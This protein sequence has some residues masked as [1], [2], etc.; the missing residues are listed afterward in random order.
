MRV[1]ISAP[2]LAS[3]ILAVRPHSLVITRDPSGLNDA[4]K[5]RPHALQIQ[6]LGP[7]PGVPDPRRVVI[8]AVKTRDPSGLND[9]EKTM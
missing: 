3:Q 5:T 6:D 9:A 1:R 8:A 7:R 2:V 4:E